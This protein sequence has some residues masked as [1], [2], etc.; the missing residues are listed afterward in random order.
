MNCGNI[1]AISTYLTASGKRRVF[2]C[3]ACDDTFS[4]TRETV[5]FDL[6]TPE[7]KVMVTLK[8]LLVGVDLTGIAFVLGVTEQTTLAWLARA[9][10]K[11][12]QINTALL[13]ALPVTQVQLDQ[14]WNF[15]RRKH[16]AEDGDGESLPACADGRQWVWIAFAPEVR[17]MLTAV[18]AART[19]EVATA[20][21]AATAER[22]RAIPAYFS[23]GFTCYFAA[24]VAAYHTW[25]RFPRTGKPGRPKQPRRV[26]HPEL[27][28]GQLVK[29]KKQGRLVTLSTRVLAGAER[30]ERLGL[31]V[32]TALIERLN[33]TVRRAL[34]PLARKTYSF[35]KQREQM[36]RRVTFFQAF[37]NF[38]RPHQ[39]LRTPLP[40]RERR[41]T[42]A[43]RPRWR[44]R[45]PAMAAGLSDHV[46][47]F[48]E[49]L[50]AKFE[51]LDSQS[52][53]G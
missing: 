52:I 28:Y 34:A 2:R 50:T 20:V 6:R 37:Y 27:V 46:W 13:R 43:I 30:L 53:T 9:A 17:L 5:F 23:D 22:V 51:P 26:P 10:A 14:M 12:D 1:S 19:Q 7:Q 31:K 42:G 29:V 36:Q 35:C 8:M 33:L 3:S 38:A 21:I 49:L 24:L 16:A 11:A 39:S 44:E 15:I 32:S 45:T 25:V 4:E 18:V 41:R 47:T 48:R 40:M